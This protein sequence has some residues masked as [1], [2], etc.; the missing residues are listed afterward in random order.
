MQGTLDDPPIVVQQDRLK[1][2]LVLLFA[3]GMTI[4]SF[5]MLWTGTAKSLT[6]AYIMSVWFVILTLIVAV[7]LLRPWRLTLDRS[8]LRRSTIWRATHYEW[9]DFSGFV[10]FS[11]SLFLRQPGGL[12]SKS[13]PKWRI[14]RRFAGDLVTLGSCWEMSPS[15]IV[16]L[17]NRG[18][19][20]WGGANQRQ[21][22]N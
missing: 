7:W 20:R 10:T 2:F 22:S 21:I 6:W 1:I 13:C 5:L 17:L 8:G 9:N 18:L 16:E 12:L 4:F 14:G 19:Q 15:E 11:P 3:I